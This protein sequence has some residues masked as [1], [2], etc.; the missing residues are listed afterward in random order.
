MAYQMQTPRQGEGLVAQS[1]A[2]L[3]DGRG[4]KAGTPDSRNDFG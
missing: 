2:E 1:G 4:G 3:V